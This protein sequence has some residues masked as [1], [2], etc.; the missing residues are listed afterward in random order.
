L[1][2]PSS[3]GGSPYAAAADGQRFLTILTVGEAES[4]P[5]VLQTG[6]RP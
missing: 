5:I 3:P 6:A 1:H 4:S 2:L